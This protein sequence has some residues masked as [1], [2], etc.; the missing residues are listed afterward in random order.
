[1]KIILEFDEKTLLIKLLSAVVAQK[2]V[3]KGI[4]RVLEI[5]Y[6]KKIEKKGG[7]YWE[8]LRNYYKN[9]EGIISVVKYTTPII[10]ILYNNIKVR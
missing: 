8:G 9:N 5:E 4:E 3:K 10:I 7:K 2:I 1:M 6:V